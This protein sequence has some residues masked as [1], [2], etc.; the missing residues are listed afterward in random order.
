MLVDQEV[1]IVPL[2]A[3]GLGDDGDGLGLGLADE[4]NQ[5]QYGYQS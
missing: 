1:A 3:D 2:G 5:R 4:T